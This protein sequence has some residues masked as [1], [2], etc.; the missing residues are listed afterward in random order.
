MR[1]R[2]VAG[3]LLFL[4]LPLFLVFSLTTFHFRQE[5]RQLRQAVL[6]D[7]WESL[8]RYL[9]DLWTGL[10][11]SL[12]YYLESDADPFALSDRAMLRDILIIR[13]DREVRSTSPRL[14][15]DPD[16][17]RHLPALL[18]SVDDAAYPA[19]AVIP[20]RNE[21]L[22]YVTDRSTGA[23]VIAFLN[24]ETIRNARDRF[25][26]D[27]PLPLV[28]EVNGSLIALGSRI[29]E[30]SYPEEQEWTLIWQDEMSPFGIRSVRSGDNSELIGPRRSA[31][32][33]LV[34]TL[35]FLMTG[36]LGFLVFDSVLYRPI[37]ELRRLVE[38]QLGREAVGPD[39]I[40]A[41]MDVVRDYTREVDT[42]QH[43][44]MS[45]L[46]NTMLIR[47][48]H[49]E[50]SD[51]DALNREAGPLGLT[52]SGGRYVILMITVSGSGDPKA[53]LRG[54]AQR[55][56]AARPD[57]LAAIPGS[58]QRIECLAQ[59]SQSTVVVSDIAA[60]LRAFVESERRDHGNVPSI[61]AGTACRAVDE[62]GRSALEA[63][64]ALDY[65]IISG[66][67][68]VLIYDEL[69]AAQRERFRYSRRDIQELEMAI[70]GGNAEMVKERMDHFI[71]RIRDK[72]YPLFI[73][74]SL[75]YD[76]VNATTHVLEEIPDERRNREFS[77]RWEDLHNFG[78]V[79]NLSEMLVRYSEMI[80]DTLRKKPVSHELASRAR[81]YI[82]DHITD[83]D[84]YLQ[85]MAD[86]F[87]QS[88]ST[89]SQL[90]K[91]SYGITMI[92]FTSRLRIQRAEELLTTTD[93]KVE[94][95]VS[96]IGYSDIS[97]FTRKFKSHVGTTP[98]AYRRKNRR[99]E[100]EDT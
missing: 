22:L 24:P 58:Q 57:I 51:P 54:V 13:P 12:E 46:R 82:S 90:F 80:R 68:D 17:L 66:E 45:D 34:A 60:E 53:S 62:L 96:E 39:E 71:R 18:S 84:F 2:L 14:A 76:I 72:E 41:L 42:Q 15:G 4:F 16:I 35:V 47:I 8:G 26:P 43:V 69:Y 19:L 59:M 7:R 91:K 100:G 11:L 56:T 49:G 5:S 36:A 98:G 33:Y 65:R 64:T 67:G 38:T 74:R 87:G 85:K 99:A 77:I 3:Y 37:V 25:L 73:A 31:G 10:G 44:V 95:I 50:Y 83:P 9:S 28:L 75:L 81:D 48:I 88:L 20:G 92:E 52:F 79:E 63:E 86:D 97:S 29:A 89:M 30:I 6:S 40:L 23:M 61:G 70:R 93:M 32:E 94:D 1:T 55:L 27:T 21:L 78:S